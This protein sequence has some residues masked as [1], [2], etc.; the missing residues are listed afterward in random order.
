[1]LNSY[2]EGYNSIRPMIDLRAVLPFY[3]FIDAFNSI[4]WSQRRGLEKNFA[5]YEVNLRILKEMLQ[6]ERHENKS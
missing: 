3:R 6:G 2:E 5:F 1:M 4:G